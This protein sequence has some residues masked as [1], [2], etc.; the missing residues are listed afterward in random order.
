MS[1]KDSYRAAC[2]RADA[3]RARLLDSLRATTAR[4]SPDRL[5]SDVRAKVVNG[6]LDTAHTLRT[7]VRERPVAASAA[8]I[9]LV[10]WLARRPLWTLFRRLFVEKTDEDQQDDRPQPETDDG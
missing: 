7:A 1:V 6:A 2:E 8:G 9:A 5:R 10:A 4:I 3:R